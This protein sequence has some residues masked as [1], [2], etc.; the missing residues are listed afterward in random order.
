MVLRAPG[1][2]LRPF[3]FA[4]AIFLVLNVLKTLL[5]CVYRYVPEQSD[6]CDGFRF[7]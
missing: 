7:I 4:A 3:R 1:G 6:N 5:L 2:C